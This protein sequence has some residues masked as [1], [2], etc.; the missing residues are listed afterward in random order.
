MFK[1]KLKTDIKIQ[2]FKLKVKFDK[3]KDI[4]KFDLE[5]LMSTFFYY[6][7]DSWRGYELK[8]DVFKRLYESYTKI[9]NKILKF[10]EIP[11]PKKYIFYY[12]L[13]KD[14]ILNKKYFFYKNDEKFKEIYF[15][16]ANLLLDSF[17]KDGFLTYE[18]FFIEIEKIKKRFKKEIKEINNQMEYFAY[19]NRKKFDEKI[20]KFFV[21]D[22]KRRK[23]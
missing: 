1:K 20:R 2:A 14:E 17:E 7:T 12:L 5:L 9:I 6:I 22:L 10:D 8:E 23:E 18:E 15:E 13:L 3:N 16:F 4:H 11:N 19:K 21:K